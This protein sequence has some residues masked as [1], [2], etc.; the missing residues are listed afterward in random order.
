L[1][2]FVRQVLSLALLT[3][4]FAVPESFRSRVLLSSE[5]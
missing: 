3:F 5:N 4:L 1:F 2:F